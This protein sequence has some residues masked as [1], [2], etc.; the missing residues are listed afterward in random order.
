MSR[1]T[2]IKGEVN[3]VLADIVADF[4]MLPN[5]NLVSAVLFGS[6]AREPLKPESDLDVLLVFEQ[7]PFSKN[8]LNDFFWPTLS[9]AQKKLKT[10]QP[11]GIHRE[12]SPV[13][14]TR[15]DALCW[16]PLYL[17]M[18]SHHRIFCD[19]HEFM[20]KTL[21][22][23]QKWIASSGSHRIERGT[24]WYWVLNGDPSDCL[25]G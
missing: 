4:E 7:L 12:F 19:K 21:M 24:K 23:V 22:K 17:D 6:E 11:Y 8:E 1:R 13:F 5:S 15:A 3:R 9:L 14:K 2:E 18:A 16:S 25:A 10:L 20:E